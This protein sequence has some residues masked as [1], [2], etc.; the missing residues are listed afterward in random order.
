MYELDFTVITLKDANTSIRFCCEKKQNTINI[1]FYD[2]TPSHGS[3]SL[4]P[5]VVCPTLLKTIKSVFT[6]YQLPCPSIL[7]PE[8]KEKEARKG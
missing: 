6:N 7:G 4:N 5:K 8:V 2:Q 1:G 3:G